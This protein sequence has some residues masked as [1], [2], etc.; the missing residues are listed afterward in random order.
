[1]TNVKV[2]GVNIKNRKMEI[3]E[4]VQKLVGSIT[5]AG[6]S[7]LDTKRLE[8]LKVMCGLIED[9]VYEVNYVARDKD[10]YESSMKEMGVYAQKFLD[11]LKEEF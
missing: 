2:A 6:E 7:H 10:R 3:K 1:M 11:N 5:P 4:I 8:N 9:L